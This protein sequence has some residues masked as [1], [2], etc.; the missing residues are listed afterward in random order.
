MHK[1]IGELLALVPPDGSPWSRPARQRWVAAIEAVLDVLYE[2]APLSTTPVSGDET[3]AGTNPSSPFVD[4]P[5]VGAPPDEQ[6]RPRQGDTTFV[7]DLRSS[8]ETRSGRGRHA[9]PATA[10]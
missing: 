8:P 5:R 4:G 7:L 3:T 1:L 6:F 2:D 10:D 9:R